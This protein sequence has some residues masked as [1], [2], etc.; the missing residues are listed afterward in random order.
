LER[1]T[2]PIVDLEIEQ[3]DSG[4]GH[5][6]PQA[7][8]GVASEL[9]PIWERVGDLSE[10]ASR[11]TAKMKNSSSVPKVTATPE[12]QEAKSPELP[13]SPPPS[14]SNKAQNENPHHHSSSSSEPRKKK[15]KRQKV[16]S[17]S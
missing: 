3:S 10:M 11:E 14:T 8:A 5:S 1:C 17:K 6:P 2:A 9:D 7:L 15:P 4:S 12:D 16:L 13:S